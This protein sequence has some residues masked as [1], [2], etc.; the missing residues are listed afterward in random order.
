MHTQIYHDIVSIYM[1][2]QVRRA[3]HRYTQ[4][5]LICRSGQRICN[6]EGDENK[7]HGMIYNEQYKHGGS[8]EDRENSFNHQYKYSSKIELTQEV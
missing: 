2:G 7:E 1:W 3:S 6:G 4:H 5:T 8:M